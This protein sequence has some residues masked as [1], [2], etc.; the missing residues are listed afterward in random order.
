MATDDG[1]G[2]GRGA[3]R[4]AGSRRTRDGA[5]GGTSRCQRTRRLMPRRTLAVPG[6]L[7]GFPVTRSPQRLHRVCRAETGTWW[8]SSDMSGR[9][10][11]QPPEGTCYFATDDYGAIREASRLGP[12]TPAWVANREIRVVP[13]P[14]SARLAATTREAAAHF[15]TTSELAT[16]IPYALPQRWAAAFR[17]AGFDGIRH[18]LRHDSRARPGGVSL[19]GRAGGTRGKI[20][21]RKALTARLMEAAGVRVLPPPDSAVLRIME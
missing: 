4:C 1:A 17:A 11:L 16:M 6:D 10:D 15:G 19:F 14:A 21:V 20:G 2:T 9:F 18:V 8:F 3:V 12:V 7:T 13:G 5:L